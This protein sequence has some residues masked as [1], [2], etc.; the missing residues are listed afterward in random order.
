MVPRRSETHMEVGTSSH[1]SFNLCRVLISAVHSNM[2]QSTSSLHIVASRR[3]KHPPWCRCL[4]KTPPIKVLVATIIWSSHSAS[5]IPSQVVRL[6]LLVLVLVGFTLDRRQLLVGMGIV[7]RKLVWDDDLDA[8]CRVIWQ[9]YVGIPPVVIISLYDTCQWCGLCCLSTIRLFPLTPPLLVAV[10]FFLLSHH[11]RDNTGAMFANFHPCM[12]ISHYYFYCVKASFFLCEFVNFMC[13]HICWKKQMLFLI[14]LKKWRTRWE[15]RQIFEVWPSQM[16]KQSPT[17][18]FAIADIIYSCSRHKKI[19]CSIDWKR[20]WFQRE[21]LFFWS[22]SY[23]LTYIQCFT[24]PVYRNTE[25]W[26]IE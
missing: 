1:F 25:R 21:S 23:D 18:S 20:W 24:T 12:T 2:F 9:S 6:A 7:E 15:D 14:S 16:K 19:L 22:G 10:L 11:V 3:T 8:I 5:P 26:V 13:P 4:H 17:G